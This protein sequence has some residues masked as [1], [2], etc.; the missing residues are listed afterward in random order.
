MALH[1]QSV[2]ASQ[3]WYTPPHVFKALGVTF[4]M[5]VA[6]TNPPVPWVP[7]SRHLWSDSL[8]QGWFGFVWMNPP[9]G[10]RNGLVPWLDKFFKHGNGIALVP[11]RTSAPWWQT[12]A[13]KADGILFISPKLKFI[14]ANGQPGN[15]PAQGTTLMAA[16]TKASRAL[17]HAAEKGL[18]LFA[19]PAPTLSSQQRAQEG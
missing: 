2:G 7:A 17:L 5:D 8:A 4:D 6:T 1:E 16:G 19:V 9:F 18:G 10:G 12:F 15:S 3:E 11:D 14:G 13:P